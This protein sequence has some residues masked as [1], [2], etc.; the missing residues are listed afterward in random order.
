[1]RLPSTA[2]PAFRYGERLEQE[3]I[4]VPIGPHEAGLVKH[5]TCR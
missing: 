5:P 2:M 4:A 3:M 1:M